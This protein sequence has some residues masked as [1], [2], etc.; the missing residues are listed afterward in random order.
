MRKPI[1]SLLRLLVSSSV[2]VACEDKPTQAASS[3]NAKRS[4]AFVFSISVAAATSALSLHPLILAKVLVVL[5]AFLTFPEHIENHDNKPEDQQ[6]Q[7]QDY[8]DGTEL[9]DNEIN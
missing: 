8:L 9:E 2:I 4:R 3:S 6:C 5:E 7:S 1:Y